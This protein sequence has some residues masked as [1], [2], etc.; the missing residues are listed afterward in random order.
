MGD[1]QYNDK[2][3]VVLTEDDMAF[4]TNMNWLCHINSEDSALRVMDNILANSNKSNIE[5][6]MR[7]YRGFKMLQP[8]QKQKSRPRPDIRIYSLLALADTCQDFASS[9]EEVDAIIDTLPTD[10]PIGL[11]K[12]MLLDG[13]AFPHFMIKTRLLQ[14]DDGFI[15]ENPLFGALTTVVDVVTI[16]DYDIEELESRQFET[17]KLIQICKLLN[18]IRRIFYGRNLVNLV[19]DGVDKQL[20]LLIRG[21]KYTDNTLS[22]LFSETPILWNLERVDANLVDGAPGPDW[23]SENPLPTGNVYTKEYSDICKYQIVLRGIRVDAVNVD[24]IDSGETVMSEA[25]T[26]RQTSENFSTNR[27]KAFIGVEVPKSSSVMSMRDRV[28]AFRDPLLYGI[29]RAGD[30]GQ[31][32][33]CIR[34]NKIFVTSDRQAALFAHFMGCNYIFMTYY[35][36]EYNDKKYPTLPAF[37]WHIFYI[38]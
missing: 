3:D 26:N 8:K 6:A 33:H 16:T 12:E 30:W 23:L 1:H 19:I 14:F 25:L 31:V 29:K 22:H 21:L 27:L 13:D 17:I 7:V 5:E 18:I 20:L 32:A 38:N 2:G 37:I 24:I 28:M 11:T 15:I 4:L 36:N 34:Y 35:E 9:I 10:L